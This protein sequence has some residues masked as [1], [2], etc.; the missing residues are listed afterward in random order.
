MANFMSAFFFAVSVSV[1]TTSLAQEAVEE[2]LQLGPAGQGYLDAAGRRVSTDAAYFDPTRTA[3]SLETD[4]TPQ[5]ARAN[6]EGAT[7]S[8]GAGSV[9]ITFC[10]ALLGVITFLFWQNGSGLSVSLRRD[11]SNPRRRRP[12]EPRRGEAHLQESE[13]LR[14][15]LSIKDRQAALILLARR[16]LAATVAANDLLLQS[17]WTARDAFNRVPKSQPHR[18]ALRDLVFAAEGAQFGD[19][20]VDEPQFQAHLERIRPLL[21]DVPA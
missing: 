8:G 17:S 21:Q 18:E 3:P 16:A 4:V 12:D 10:A 1:A 11:L 20:P 13:D 2:P 9:F 14:T 15:I 5:D 7:S 19:R 6:D